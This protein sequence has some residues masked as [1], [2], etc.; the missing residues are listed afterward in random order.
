M[1]KLVYRDAN[2]DDLDALAALHVR[3]WRDTYRLL[4]PTAAYEALD[5]AKRRQ[6]WDELLRRDPST[7]R[8]MVAEYNGR[9]VGLGHAGTGTHEVMA[10][11]GEIVHLY[12]DPEMQGRGIGSSLLLE[13]RRFL[14]ASGHPVV[15]L[16]VVEGN[17]QALRFYERAGGRI[18]GDFVD[19][20]LWRSHNHIVEFPSIAMGVPL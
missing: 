6:H 11:A 17:S 13:L 20:V 16:A 1:E 3:V 19:G 2:W 18:V 5:E 8:T 14:M 12:V 10:G 15:R 7:W 9:L 4:A